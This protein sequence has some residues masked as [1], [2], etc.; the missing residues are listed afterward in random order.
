MYSEVAFAIRGASQTVSS[1]SRAA[2]CRV[3]FILAAEVRCMYLSTIFL[4][5]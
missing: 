3:P 4:H 1:A 5:V 2:K